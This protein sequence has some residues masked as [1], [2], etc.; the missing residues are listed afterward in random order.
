MDYVR[1]T[2]ADEPVASSAETKRVDLAVFVAPP[3]FLQ[4][5][6]RFS[7]E[8]SNIHTFFTA[9]GYFVSIEGDCEI[10]EF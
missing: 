3:H 9:G 4:H 7:V 6:P 2:G 5:L 10:T 8:Q 1:I